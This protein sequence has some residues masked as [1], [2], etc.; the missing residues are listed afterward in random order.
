MNLGRNRRTFQL[1]LIHYN[2][3]AFQPFSHSHF[4]TEL[5]SPKFLIS[6]AF[7][8]GRYPLKRNQS[9]QFEASEARN[10][11]TLEN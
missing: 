1:V 11:C 3:F 9:I 4:I 10:G 8:A 2:L 6:Q 5:D 7:F